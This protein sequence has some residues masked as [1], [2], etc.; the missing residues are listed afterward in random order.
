MIVVLG[1]HALLSSKI[2][3]MATHMNIL[4]NFEVIYLKHPTFFCRPSIFIN[5]NG[6]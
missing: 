1:V 2:K 3:G 6:F 4:Q 5:A